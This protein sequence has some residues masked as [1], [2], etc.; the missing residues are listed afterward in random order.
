LR[1]EVKVLVPVFWI[2]AILAVVVIL[3]RVAP[4]VLFLLGLAIILS[5]FVVLAEG[6][7]WLVTRRPFYATRWLIRPW[8]RAREASRR[9]LLE[10]A[11]AAAYDP[12]R[13]WQDRLDALAEAQDWDGLIAATQ[14]VR[15][16]GDEQLSQLLLRARAFAE[17]GKPGP[18]LHVY[19]ECLSSAKRDRGL[20]MRARYERGKLQLGLGRRTQARRELARV[21]AQD[22]SF[23]DVA[24]LIEQLEVAAA[25]TLRE[26]IPQE[27]RDRVWQRDQGRCVQCGSRERLEYDHIIPVA[28][29]GANTERNLQLLCETCNRA[30]GATI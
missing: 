13:E 4:F 21:Y 9:R 14:G 11:E 25:S 19:G 15:N 7:A 24:V 27:V 8:S 28:K 23:R 18:A 29:G 20:L 26:P 30:K 1:S 5:A 10:A 6:A 22:P 2:F 17:A 12:L 3:A 16:D